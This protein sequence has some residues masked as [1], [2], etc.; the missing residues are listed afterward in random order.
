MAG[1][2]R[3][4]KAG[5]TY[6]KRFHK[7]HT[8]VHAVRVIVERYVYTYIYIYIQTHRRSSLPLFLFIYEEAS[9]LGR[10]AENFLG[11]AGVAPRFSAAS[12][13]LSLCVYVSVSFCDRRTRWKDSGDGI[14]I[15]VIPA[16][17]FPSRREFSFSRRFYLFSIILAT[18]LGLHDSKTIQYFCN[19]CLALINSWKCFSCLFSQYE[20]YYRF[21][22]KFLIMSFLITPGCLGLR[23][24]LNNRLA[25]RRTSI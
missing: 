5:A 14:V 17:S 15:R 12:L 24:F 7:E 25:Y 13:R 16:G 8:H 20:K 2:K 4:E 21:V 23:F 3:R 1:R 10:D 22:L 9:R 19:H 6:A 11:K 18:F